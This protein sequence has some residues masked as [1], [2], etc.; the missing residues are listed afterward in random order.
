MNK[1]IN[2]I[3]IAPLMV[4]ILICTIFSTSSIVFASS[5]IVDDSTKA[6]V[7]IDQSTGKVL[8]EKNK[9][10]ILPQA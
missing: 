1:N 9:D 4:V 7:L 8:Y 6:A 2:K 10:I 5:N 3:V